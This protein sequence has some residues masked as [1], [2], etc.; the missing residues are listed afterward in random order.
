MDDLTCECAINDPP[1]DLYPEV[2]LHH[3]SC[4]Q[5]RMIAGIGRVVRCDTVDGASGGE[6]DARL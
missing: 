3:I 1:L 4:A 5:Y 6:A 2:Q